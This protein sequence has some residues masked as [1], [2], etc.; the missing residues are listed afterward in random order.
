MGLKFGAPPGDSGST[1][2]RTGLLLC[3]RHNHGNSHIK[4]PIMSGN[5]SK[6]HDETGQNKH[7]K[8]HEGSDDVIQLQSDF[9]QSFIV[10]QNSLMW[11]KR[12]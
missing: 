2:I 1:E 5:Y 4:E 10:R 3:R 11:L 6:S 12:Q 7:G 8:I 9:R